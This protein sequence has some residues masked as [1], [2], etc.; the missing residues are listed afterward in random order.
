MEEK[1]TIRKITMSLTMHFVMREKTLRT[2]VGAIPRERLT[3]E[4]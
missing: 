3:Y 4:D 1:A 2:I